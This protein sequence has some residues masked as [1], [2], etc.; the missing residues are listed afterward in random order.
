MRRS[1]RSN[2]HNQTARSASQSMCA[3]LRRRLRKSSWVCC[4]AVAAS[5]F[6][7][8]LT[9]GV[10]Y[11]ALERVPLEALRSRQHA[12][13]CGC[14]SSFVTRGMAYVAFTRI[15]CGPHVVG[16][17]RRGGSTPR[18]S[19]RRD[20][21][22]G[23]EHRDRV[24]ERG[25]FRSLGLRWCLLY[26]HIRTG[27]SIGAVH[28]RARAMSLVGDAFR[29]VR[30]AGAVCRCIAWPSDPLLRSFLVKSVAT[31]DVPATVIIGSICRTE[32]A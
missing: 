5:A 25:L 26:A 4:S 7:A 32:R 28:G 30:S 6:V 15:T 21:T 10:A 8:R 22:V 12:R 31:R 3:Y 13:R 14:R 11:G 2:G 18:C 20:C 23:Q 19:S 1:C 16:G 17:L 24:R 27:S 29:R 9:S